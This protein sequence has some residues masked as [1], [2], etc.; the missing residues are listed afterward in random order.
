MTLPAKQTSPR[1]AATLVEQLAPTVASLRG[2]AYSQLGPRPYRVFLVVRTWSED[3][4]GRGDATVDRTE[5]GC[6]P[7]GQ[8]G[9]GPC[10][11]TL[12][13]QF[14]RAVQGV[15]DDGS[16]L[17]EGIDPTLTEADLD[18]TPRLPQ[19]AE[20]WYEIVADGRDGAIPDTVVRE[21]V[22]ASQPF[23]GPTA[24]SW[25]LRLTARQ[26]NGGAS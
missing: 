3:A 24:L 17:V 4:P 23:R 11:V 13:G 9:V 6:G 1:P 19:G 12:A 18:P 16:A 2:Q 25:V 26:P 21:Y 20:C 15:L 7:N 5:I 14:A 10:A 8:G 22:L